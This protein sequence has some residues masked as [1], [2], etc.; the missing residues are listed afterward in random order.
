MLTAGKECGTDLKELKVQSGFG[1]AILLDF[2][3]FQGPMINDL[4]QYPLAEPLTG[5][6]LIF[7]YP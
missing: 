6:F 4:L 1:T 2:T 7:Y 3:L 5:F